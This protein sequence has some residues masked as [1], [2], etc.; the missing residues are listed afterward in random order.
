MLPKGLIMLPK[1]PNRKKIYYKITN[2][3]ENHRG[4]QYRDGLIIDPIKFNDNSKDSCVEGGIYFTTKEYLHKFFGYGYWIRPIKLPSDANVVLDPSGDK[5][6]AD[7]LF[8]KP[9]KD[10]NFYFDELFN[11]K[12][13]PEEE[14][15]YLAEY[16][17]KY[18]DKWFDKKT[19]PKKDYWY[20]AKYCSNYFTKW[21]DKKTFPEEDYWYL[22]KYCSK[23]FDKWFDKKTFPKKG[24]WRLAKHCSKHFNKWFDK[25]TFPEEDYKYLAEYCSKYI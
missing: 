7:S 15:K 14:Y 17:S 11:K 12:T 24:Y 8:F 5:Y 18:F 4:L 13:F 2:Q 21:F 9:R 25:K 1:I 3:K 6:R 10:F 20:L 23:Y 22:A 19:F 16:C